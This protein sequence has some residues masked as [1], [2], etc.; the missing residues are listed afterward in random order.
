[1][2]Q[3]SINKHLIGCL[4]VSTCIILAGCEIPSKPNFSIEHSV[5]V[6][7]LTKDLP[8]LGG[9]NALVDTSRTG[10]LHIFD[11]KDNGV[12][13]FTTM[14]NYAKVLQIQGLPKLPSGFTYPKGLMVNLGYDDPSNGI[15]TLDLFN[16][17]EAKISEIK[18]LEYFSKRIGSFSILNASMNLF[19]KTNLAAGNDVFAGVVGVDPHNNQTYLKPISGS[20]YAVD[21]TNIN[22]LWSHNQALSKS[23]ILKFP[24]RQQGM[25]SDTLEGVVTFDQSNS[26]FGDFIANLPTEVRFIGK[27]EINNP[28]LTDKGTDIYFDTAVGLDIPLEIATPAQPAT[29][30]DTISV[31]FSNLPSQQNN[32]NI[33]Q[34]EIKIYYVNKLPL[35]AQMSFQMLDEFHRPLSVSIPD[36]TAGYPKAILDPAQVDPSTLFSSD[37]SRGVM[38][39]QLTKDQINVLNQT[40]FM[41]VR[42]S[43][44]TTNDKPVRIQATDYIRLTMSGDFS[45]QSNV[46][47]KGN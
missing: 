2:Y 9:A 8:F 24:I 28:N 6:P 35:S 7:L 38:Q 26:N 30:V 47:K 46:N 13:R 37:P 5:Q 21:S 15:D 31:D 3:K 20:A 42:A 14:T 17:L 45:I 34:G 10:L 44:Q 36:T 4:L 40:K 22:G 19:Y 39:I 12:V 43:L 1:M 11:I 23:Q 25:S 18:D 27:A 33:S 41:I 32:S 29:Y 16:D